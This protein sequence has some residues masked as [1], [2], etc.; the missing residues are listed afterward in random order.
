MI[1]AQTLLAGPSIPVE[2]MQDGT[3]VYTWEG[4]PVSK[5]MSAT[6]VSQAI[7]IL[8]V[9]TWFSGCRDCNHKNPERAKRGM[10]L[11]VSAGTEFLLK[12]GSYVAVHELATGT[13]LLAI[14][15][16]CGYEEVKEVR[17]V[18]LPEPVTLYAVSGAENYGITDGPHVLLVR[19]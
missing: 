19:G 13:R 9:E 7:E 11:Q 6:A 16:K 1:P 5:P 8:E 3:F 12:N 17:T 15:C 2:Q 18:I 4:H 14:G 10:V